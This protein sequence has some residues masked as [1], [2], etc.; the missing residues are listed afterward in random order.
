MAEPV[1]DPSLMK[2]KKKK[3]TIVE[4]GDGEDIKD[5]GGEVAEGG[6]A[7]A[8]SEDAVP[9]EFDFGKKKKKEKKSKTKAL[10]EDEV[11]GGATQ[12]STAGVIAGTDLPD[13]PDW[14]D[15][16]YDEL[17]DRVY[18]IMRAKNPDLGEKKKFTMK[19]PQCMRVGTRKTGFANFTEICR[20]LKRP[21]KHI[22]QFLLAELGTSGSL[23]GNTYL[24][25]KGRFQQKHFESVLKKYI[26]EYVTC[27][28]CKSPDTTMHKEGRLFF[29]Q[30][31]ACG[32]R[33]SVSAIKSGF[34]AVT[35]K[36]AAIR[37]AMTT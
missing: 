25:V 15:H 5:E 34:Q 32:S 21:P 6:E 26:K 19:P 9:T 35:T 3:K 20:L 30:C 23:D 22:M 8:A 36:R 24:I 31:D 14:P 27:H 16:T 4:T 17:L 1:F 37:A 2:K 10:A 28:T 18:G 7:V 12:A 33:C 13:Y 29:L 11:D